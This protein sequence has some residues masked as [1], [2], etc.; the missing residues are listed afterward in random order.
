MRA[1]QGVAFHEV[2]K[3]NNAADAASGKDTHQWG[4]NR[5]ELF[6][7]VNISLSSL[8]IHLLSLSLLL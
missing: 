4:N 3:Q 2:A 1:T 7:M 5:G 8:V 6:I